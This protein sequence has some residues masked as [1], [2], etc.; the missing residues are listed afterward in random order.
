V[1]TFTSYFVVVAEEFSS[2]NVILDEKDIPG[3]AL[4]VRI[5]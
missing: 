1:N 2:D 5:L 4:G 3:A